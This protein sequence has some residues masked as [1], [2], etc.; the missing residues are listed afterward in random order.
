MAAAVWNLM[1]L[2]HTEEMIRRGGLPKELDDLPSY[3]QAA[4][5][6]ERRYLHIPGKLRVVEKRGEYWWCDDRW[7]SKYPAS[8]RDHNHILSEGFQEIHNFNE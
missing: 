8:Y 7:G 2:I 3:V 5:P 1:A 6:T 4:K